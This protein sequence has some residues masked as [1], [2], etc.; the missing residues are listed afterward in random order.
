MPSEGEYQSRKLAVRLLLDHMHRAMVHHAMWYAEAER[1]YGRREAMKLLDKVLE[2]TLPIQLNRLGKVL[3]FTVSEAL[4]DAF[5]D[6]PEESFEALKEAIAVNWLANDGV[7]FQAVEFSRG[8]E[9]AKQCNDNC[10]S[11]FSPFEAASIARLLGL[12]DRPGL[13]GLK[14][15]LQFRLY[16]VINKQS[17][18]EEKPDSFIFRMDNCRVQAARKRKGLPDY[19]CKSGG[20]VEYSSFAET[21]DPGIRTEC[22]CCPPDDHPSDY[23][24]AW[25]FF[26]ADMQ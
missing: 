12:P 24:C 26:I 1:R 23:F 17:I 21:I 4:P 22:I 8:M 18:A 19:P 10:W 11:V 16:A 9:E 5:M 20:M 6:L 2:T 15:A 7:W 14:K 3:G 25:R 13:E